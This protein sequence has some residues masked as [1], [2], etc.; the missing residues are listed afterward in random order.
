[1]NPFAA[2]FSIKCFNNLEVLHRHE[3]IMNPYTCWN[4]NEWCIIFGGSKAGNIECPCVRWKTTTTPTNFYYHWWIKTRGRFS[5]FSPNTRNF[6]ALLLAKKQEKLIHMW[7]PRARSRGCFII[8]GN[9]R[10]IIT[11][12]T[13]LTLK[14]LE[15]VKG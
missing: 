12:N 1:M 10:L 2:L 15:N 8:K 9:S 13:R 14:S 7:P 5:V 11:L 4:C 3:T 6:I